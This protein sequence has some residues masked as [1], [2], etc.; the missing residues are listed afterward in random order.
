MRTEGGEGEGGYASL[1]Y[2]LGQFLH[3]LLG[4]AWK[5]KKNLR[6]KGILN[7]EKRDFN[8]EERLG[9]EGGWV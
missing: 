2:C 3:E 4:K 6:R 7:A 1:T 9:K 8:W 5:G